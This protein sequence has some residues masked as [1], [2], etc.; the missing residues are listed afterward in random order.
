MGIEAAAVPSF[1]D[2]PDD[3]SPEVW[4][5]AWLNFERAYTHARIAYRLRERQG[6]GFWATTKEVLSGITGGDGE[7]NARYDGVTYLVPAST[8]QRI[9]EEVL[10]DAPSRIGAIRGPS[11]EIHEQEIGEL[12]DFIQRISGAVDDLGFATDS[13]YTMRTIDGTLVDLG[14]DNWDSNL[15]RVVREEAVN[16]VERAILY[17]HNGASMLEYHLRIYQKVQLQSRRDIYAHLLES[18]AAFK[19][20]AGDVKADMTFD[21]TE[22]RNVIGQVV[23]AAA[24]GINPITRGLA[25]ADIIEMVNGNTGESGIEDPK[26]LLEA[27]EKT[28]EKVRVSFD[29]ALESATAEIDGYLSF[30]SGVPLSDLTLPEVGSLFQ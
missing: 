28:T 22:F 27:F 17:L 15:A 14:E 10:G 4:D 6:N 20:L 2:L 7:A 3:Y 23:A 12:D 8:G 30:L 25:V 13:S 29:T 5:T 24:K 18:I 11:E 21:Y 1:D 9:A 19:G 26:R 16:K